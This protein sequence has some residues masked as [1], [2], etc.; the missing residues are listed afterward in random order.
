MLLVE[1]PP[2]I[3][4]HNNK[5]NI[6]FYSF[7]V[8]C[9]YDVNEF[10]EKVVWQ[11]NS[12]LDN[13]CDEKTSTTRLAE[14]AYFNENVQII[15]NCSELNDENRNLIKLKPFVSFIPQKKRFLHKALMYQLNDAN[16]AYKYLKNKFPE[17][18]ISISCFLITFGIDE[19]RVL[20]DKSIIQSLLHETKKKTFH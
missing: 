14:T 19:E 8:D 2:T 5:N 20:E 7:F 15:T 6:E 10:L 16:T 13:L 11:V 4:Y 12:L 1:K 18:N 9:S 3:I 17:I